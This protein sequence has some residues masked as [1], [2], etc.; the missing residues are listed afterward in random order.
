M[1]DD[2]IM[3]LIVDLESGS[4]R[5]QKRAERYRPTLRSDLRVRK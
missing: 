1:T 2:E 4:R 3:T 5:T